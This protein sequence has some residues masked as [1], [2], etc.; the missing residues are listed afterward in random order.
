MRDYPGFFQEESVRGAG[1]QP[2]AGLRCGGSEGSRFSVHGLRLK[3]NMR[4]SA[5]I[6]GSR[7][8]VF[9]ARSGAL[10]WI[11]A[12]AGMPEGRQGNAREEWQGEMTA[13]KS[14]IV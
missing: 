3:G 11:P 8:S 7:L 10:D 12:F 13:G 14:D 5:R 6:C 4:S 9:S 1:F 2:R